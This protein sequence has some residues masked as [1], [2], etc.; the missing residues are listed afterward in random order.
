VGAEARNEVT[1]CYSLFRTVKSLSGSLIPSGSLL[2]LAIRI[3]HQSDPSGQTFLVD[4]NKWE[5]ENGL[6]QY[7]VYTNPYSLS[8]C[9]SGGKNYPLVHGHNQQFTELTT[10]SLRLLMKYVIL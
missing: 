8:F 5:N 4:N 3:I 6:L 1:V 9:L 10:Q 7:I 2:V